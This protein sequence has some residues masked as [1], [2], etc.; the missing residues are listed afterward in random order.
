MD[1]IITAGGIPGP[2]DPIYAYTQGQ[3]KALLDMNGRTMLERVVDALQESRHVDDIVV[4]GLG[5]D[6]GQ[7][8]RRPVHHLPDHGGLFSNG[9]AGVA[10]LRQHKGETG[11]ILVCSGDVP[12][13]T[14]AQIDAHIEACQ[15]LD[16][17]MYYTFATRQVIE[18]RFPQSN[19]TYVKLKGL[20]IAG[21]DVVVADPAITDENRELWTALT[22]SRKHAWK[23]ARTVGFTLLFKL[24]LRQ[25]RLEDIENKATDIIGRPTQVI[26]TPYAELAMDVD[27]P[28]QVEMLRQFFHNNEK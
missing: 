13:I 28:R 14:A 20:E 10:W 17:A 26:L 27:K 4:V 23:L 9:L 16:K 15:P 11:H 19:R 21:G 25:L 6:H 22:E 3:S 12:A 8:F 5:H 1:C 18:A 2:D 7:Q 24:L